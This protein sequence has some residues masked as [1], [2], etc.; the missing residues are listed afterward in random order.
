MKFVREIGKLPLGHAQGYG[1]HKIL[2]NNW[3]NCKKISKKANKK[4]V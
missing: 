3:L 1:S 2:N 4:T